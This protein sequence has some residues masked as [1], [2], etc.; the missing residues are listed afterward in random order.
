MAS[1]RIWRDKDKKNIVILDS[2]AIMMLFEF[3]IDLENELTRLLG[4]YHIVIPHLVTRELEILSKHGQG[5]KRL[6]AK[7][8]LKLI[9][10]YEIVEIDEEKEDVDRAV[11]RLAKK[12]QAKV[13]TNDKQ[14]RK[15]L[16]KASLQVIF[17]RGKKK[18]VLE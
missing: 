14:L 8:A 6:K 11:L 9:E 4:T 5:K 13:A 3:S 15:E 17:L 12:L 18:L 16:K 10:K 1:N 7:A 2:S